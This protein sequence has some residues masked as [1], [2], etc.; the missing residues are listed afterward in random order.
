MRKFLQV[1]FLGVVMILTLTSCKSITLYDNERRLLAN[2]VTDNIVTSG[3]KNGIEFEV[4]I[5]DYEKKSRRVY[6]FAKTNDVY[7]CIVQ[8]SFM[9]EYILTGVAADDYEIPEG[10]TID[11]DLYRKYYRLN[12]DSLF[13]LDR[14]HRFKMQYIDVTYSKESKM[15]TENGVSVPLNIDSYVSFREHVSDIYSDNLLDISEAFAIMVQ[16]VGNY[17]SIDNISKGSLYAGISASISRINM[18]KEMADTGKTVE[19]LNFYNR[20]LSEDD[21]ETFVKWNEEHVKDWSLGAPGAYSI[22]LFMTNDY[23][24][25]FPTISIKPYFQTTLDQVQYHKELFYVDLYYTFLS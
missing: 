15:F 7:E 11:N 19:F 10:I 2:I 16:S 20:Y 25:V 3:T 14:M 12:S 18:E 1:L 9:N 4:F 17:G 5:G 6:Y 21:Y 13:T 24:K 23:K 8:K 22:P